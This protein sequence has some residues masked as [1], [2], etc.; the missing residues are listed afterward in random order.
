MLEPKKIDI[1]SLNESWLNSRCSNN[2]IRMEGYNIYRLGRKIKHRGGGLCV[3]VLGRHIVNAQ[4]Y[5]HL[6]QS[7][8]DIEVLVLEIE[9]KNTTPYILLMVYRPPQGKQ[10]LFVDKLCET[11]ETL[12]TEK[13]GNKLLILGDLNIDLLTNSDTKSVRELKALQHETSLEQ[14]IKQRT[15]VT[16]STQSL[17]D[18]MYTSIPNDL[19]A[20]SG[21]L[22]NSV[23]DH[24]P[25]FCLIKK[26]KIVIERVLFIS[27]RRA[28]VS[29]SLFFGTLLKTVSGQFSSRNARNFVYNISH[30]SSIFSHS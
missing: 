27:S 3:Y 8:S 14:L 23:S 24:F 7:D 16:H 13:S 11:I 29:H 2:S 1:L 28:A 21:V 26:P 15:R 17:I 18:H 22:D 6:N 9:Q 25:I 4:I 30:A 20:D 12:I 5:E 10:Q 19:I